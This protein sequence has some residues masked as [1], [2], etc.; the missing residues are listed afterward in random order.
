MDARSG[1]C[2]LLG[3][4]EVQRRATSTAIDADLLGLAALRLLRG[5]VLP[6]EVNYSNPAYQLPRDVS[7]VLPS[8][9][10][11]CAEEEQ[12]T[13]MY[14]AAVVAWRRGLD[15]S[16]P[17]LACAGTEGAA[18]LA[19]LL[20]EDPSRRMSVGELL[21]HPWIAD[22]VAD[23]C[24]Q[25][26]DAAATHSALRVAVRAITA[27]LTQQTLA[28]AQLSQPTLAP[29]QLSQPTLV[30][31]HCRSASPDSAGVEG[32]P[33]VLQADTSCTSAAYLSDAGSPATTAGSTSRGSY[34]W[35]ASLVPAAFRPNLAG[36]F[37]RLPD[38]YRPDMAALCLS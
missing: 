25:L 17:D 29:A 12:R 1:S 14:A 3:S 18:V 35:A 34:P 38:R 20:H 22:E 33:A 10:A 24:A 37:R 23:V 4:A 13:G 30:A 2:V 32:Q 19:A 36:L 11:R 31:C 9:S 27:Q 6:F 15:A 7:L 21:A 16:S 26:A 8:E 5:G 28:P